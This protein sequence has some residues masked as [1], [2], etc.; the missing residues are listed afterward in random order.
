MTAVSI[1]P[2]PR[3]LLISLL[4]SVGKRKLS[5]RLHFYMCR[6]ADKSLAFERNLVSSRQC[7]FSQGGHYAPEM[8]DL[9]FK[10]LKHL[11]YSP[12]LA[13]SD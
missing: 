7:Y 10:V 8:A 13:P 5:G 4:V 1:C 2:F 9:Q 12:D 6:G 11:A 3:R